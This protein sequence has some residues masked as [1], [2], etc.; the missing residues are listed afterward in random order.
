MEP[1]LIEIP[2]TLGVSVGVPPTSE[3][4]QEDMIVGEWEEGNKTSL[5]M[6]EDIYLHHKWVTGGR[7]G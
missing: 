7:R 3:G 2:E 4:E 5:H 6:V 1:Y